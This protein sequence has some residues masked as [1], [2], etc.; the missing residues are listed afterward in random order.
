MELQS[1]TKGFSNENKPDAASVQLAV[2]RLDKMFQVILE[3]L[4]I[5]FRENGHR[6]SDSLKMLESLKTLEEAP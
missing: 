2:E 6:G 5:F 4:I 1:A 3:S